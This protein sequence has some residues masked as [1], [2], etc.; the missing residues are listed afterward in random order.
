MDGNSSKEN[1]KNDKENNE[2]KKDL[3][4]EP[5]VGCYSLEVAKQF[6]VG[7]LD[8]RCALLNVRVDSE[9]ERKRT[10]CKDTQLAGTGLAKK[11][12]LQLKL[13]DH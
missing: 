2:N 9:A 10:G 1:Y 5:P 3:D 8:G 6:A 11:T 13:Q 7:S 12:R 4:H